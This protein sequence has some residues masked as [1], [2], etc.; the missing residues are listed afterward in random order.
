MLQQAIAVGLISI[1]FTA[2]VAG[3]PLSFY[4]DDAR[5]LL[6][7]LAGLIFFYAG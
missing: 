4:L 3:V 6:L 5:W 7:S 2:L 1:A